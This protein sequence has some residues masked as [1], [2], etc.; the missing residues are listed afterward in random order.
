[1]VKNAVYTKDAPKPL[2]AY[3][4]AIKAGE[5]VFTS[6]Q[7]PIDP[8]TNQIVG[9]TIEEQTRQVILNL[10]AI[11]EKAGAGLEAVV[12]TNVYLKD[13]NDLQAMNEVYGEFFDPSWTARMVFQAARLPRD[14]LVIMDMTAFLG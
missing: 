5:F 13:L 11:L 8:A 12:K 1:M 9:S 4:Q 10:K 14:V 7:L 3:S 6:G 2:G